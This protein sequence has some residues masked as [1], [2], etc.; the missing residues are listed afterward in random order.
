MRICSSERQEVFRKWVGHFKINRD[1]MSAV[2]DEVWWWIDLEGNVFGASYLVVISGGERHGMKRV[3]LEC[4]R[5]AA[6][7]RELAENGSR[8]NRMFFLELEEHW[9]HL[10]CV[11]YQANV[12]M[13]ALRYLDKEKEFGDLNYS[14]HSLH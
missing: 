9:L 11:Y 12:A 6:G 8:S 2:A 13:D 10:A 3:A 7:F 4:E 14:G 5:R 1:G